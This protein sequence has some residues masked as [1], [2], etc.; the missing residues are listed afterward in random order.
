MNYFFDLIL[1]FS[2]GNTEI[3]VTLSEGGL[4]GAVYKLVRRY[5]RFSDIAFFNSRIKAELA[6]YSYVRKSIPDY[7]TK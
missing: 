5:G 2:D 6:F 1:S 3:Y 4:N 7:E